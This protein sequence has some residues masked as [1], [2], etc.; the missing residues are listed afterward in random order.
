[1]SQQK[2]K[3]RLI[4]EILAGSQV[5]LSMNV[6]GAAAAPMIELRD[7]LNLFGYPSVEDI[8]GRL[9]GYLEEK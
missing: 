5:P 1:M 9:Q 4:A 8:E 7:Q 2:S 6:L 3:I